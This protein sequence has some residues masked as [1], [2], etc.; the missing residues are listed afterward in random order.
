ML[1][2]SA[3]H[4]L[5]PRLVSQELVDDADHLREGPYEH[6]G[7]SVD[8]GLGQTPGVVIGDGRDPVARRVP[9]PP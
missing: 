6:P 2:C 3:P 4:G 9:T 8:D 7:L 5:T 1:G